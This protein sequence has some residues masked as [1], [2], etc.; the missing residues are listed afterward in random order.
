MA[1][2]VALMSGG[3]AA[4]KNGV[5]IAAAA[6]STCCCGG[7][8]SCICANA[9][10]LP[11]GFQIYA[12]HL[13]K[14]D[15][16][17]PFEYIFGPTPID[18]CCHA[19][20][21]VF[22]GRWH[23]ITYD[24]NGCLLRIATITYSYSN[25][26]MRQHQVFDIP[27]VACGP[28]D[29]HE[30]RDFD[31][32][33]PSFCSAISHG[34]WLG[35][36]G[37]GFGNGLGIT[38]WERGNCQLY[39]GHQEQRA[40]PGRLTSVRDYRYQLSTDRGDCIAPVCKACCLSDGSCTVITVAAC[41]AA[42]GIARPDNNC[43]PCLDASIPF[44]G[45]CC[46][47]DGS[48]ADLRQS[49]CLARLGHWD[50]AGTSCANGSPCPPPPR[51]AC[52]LG[53]GLCAEY[54]QV[55]CASFFGQ[56]FPNNH[57][58]DPGVCPPPPTGACCLPSGAGAICQIMTAAQCAVFGGAYKGNGTDCSLG[59][60]ACLGA[61]CQPNPNSPTG[62]TCEDAN[63]EVFCNSI[64]GR[65]LGY[66]PVVCGQD[67]DPRCVGG[68]GIHSPPRVPGTRGFFLDDHLRNLYQHAPGRQPD[69]ACPRP[70]LPLVHLRRARRGVLAGNRGCLHRQRT[71][72]RE[73]YRL[74]RT[75]LSQGK[76]PGGR[77]GQVAGN[78]VVRVPSTVAMVL[79]VQRTD[80]GLRVHGVGQVV[81]D[82]DSA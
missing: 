74:M 19:E 60:Q 29:L 67:P 14:N 79:Q 56:W 51:Q 82:T 6:A 50:G 76:A 1:T 9:A 32:E 45:R 22:S 2:G 73:A 27:S 52:C 43:I 10:C 61:C 78:P 21:T 63:G 5:A 8:P 4:M 37:G 30:E 64:G 26:R 15:P 55:E 31:D 59:D 69:Q 53:P 48:C 36:V 80:P 65:W 57:C 72:H 24:F 49:V 23:E 77:H 41:L 11:A 42:G 16:N 62:F 54:T 70:H 28:L 17:V 38:G 47:P 46:L 71:A 33:Y 68:I 34:G 66:F 44:L 12:Y 3:V 39:E 75:D 20:T 40:V 58:T 35:A 13:V 81:V 18:C 25:G 7:G